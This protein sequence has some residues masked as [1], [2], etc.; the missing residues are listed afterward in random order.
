MLVHFGNKAERPADDEILRASLQTLADSF[1]APCE[2]GYWQGGEAYQKWIAGLGND[3]LWDF[4]NA[5]DDFYRRSSVNQCTLRSLTDE[6]RCAC[7]YLGE[8]GQAE[9]AEMY[10]GIYESVGAFYRKWLGKWDKVPD[11]GAEWRAKE[12][13]LLEKALDTERAIAEKARTVLER[14]G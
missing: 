2:R 8:C 7:A 9:L 6:R 1:N 13:R 14:Q 5:R 3:S 10:R 4:E 12:V 11:S